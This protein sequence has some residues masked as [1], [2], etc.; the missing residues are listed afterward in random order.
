MFASSY[1]CHDGSC[2]HLV[3]AATTGRVPACCGVCVC[4][5]A[6][7]CGRIDTWFGIL[8]P[9]RLTALLLTGMVF[10]TGWDYNAIRLYDSRQYEK[11]GGSLAW[12]VPSLS[13][14]PFLPR[15]TASSHGLKWNA[16]VCLRVLTCVCVC[17]CVCVV[18]CCR[19]DRF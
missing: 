6:R 14:F 16:D 17:V 11:V 4:A 12:T 2:S 19:R 3:I 13:L 8:L 7:V 15:V 1:R 5:R 18:R 10:G 9:N